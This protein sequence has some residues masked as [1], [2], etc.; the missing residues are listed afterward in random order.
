MTLKSFRLVMLSVLMCFATAWVSAD[1]ALEEPLSLSRVLKLADS[2][3]PSTRRAELDLAWSI[4]DADFHRSANPLNVEAIFFPRRVDRAAPGADNSLNDS[5][6]TLRL[7]YPLY[8]FG[9]KRAEINLANVAFER[10]KHTLEVVRAH[11]RI[12]IMR[13]FFDVLIADLSYGVQN[14]KMTLSFLRYNRFLQEMEM[15]QSHAEVDVLALETVYREEFRKRQAANIDRLRTRRNLA[16]FLGLTDH[17]PRDLET[18]DLT[19]YVEREVPEFETLL[20]WIMNGNFDMRQAELN[21]QKAETA[22]AL[23]AAKYNPQLDAVVEATRWEE[24]T[25]SRNA[26]SIGIQFRL[27]LAVGERRRRDARLS[28][29]AIDKAQLKLTETEHA[30]RVRAFELWQTLTLHHLD[31]Q[32]SATRIEFRDQYMDRARTLYE[33]EERSDLGDAQ[34]ELLRAQ[35]QDHQV[36]FKLA[37]VW[38]E[39]DVLMGRSVYPY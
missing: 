26:A 27:P 38:S 6:A 28:Q 33:L 37:L 23:T 1:D 21:L 17:I 8:D 7:T 19:M 10:A 12:D 29:L 14:E 30:V 3:H 32:S 5:Q 36:K 22:A 18:P 35:L 13:H 25:G 4:V 2:D 39:I 24:K 11:R 16:L 20:E 15:H 31:L 9:R 34:T